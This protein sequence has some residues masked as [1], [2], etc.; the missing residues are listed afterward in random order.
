MAIKFKKFVDG[1]ELATTS[2]TLYTAP[3]NTTSQIQDVTVCNT[4]TAAVTVDIY[5]VESGGSVGDP[6]TVIDGKTI[7]A[8]E[9]QTLSDLTG[10][11]LET[12][13]TLRGLASVATTLSIQASGIE[14]T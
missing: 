7:G 8:K 14:I 13:D 6:T 5:V 11:V 9:T 4:G 3:A 10:V 12:A 2:S 1:T